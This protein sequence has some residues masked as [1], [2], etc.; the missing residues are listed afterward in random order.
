M[1][2]RDAGDTIAVKFHRIR[3]TAD[4]RAAGIHCAIGCIPQVTCV[5]WL[6]NGIPLP[7]ESRFSRMHETS[8]RWYRRHRAFHINGPVSG[9]RLER[10]TPFAIAPPAFHGHVR[11]VPP[12]WMRSAGRWRRRRRG[13]T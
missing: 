9:L 5:S 1:W 7:A 6:H 13:E 3:L 11:T 12:G 10:R 2:K 8:R 4:S